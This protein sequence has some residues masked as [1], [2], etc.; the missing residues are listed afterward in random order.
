M[1]WVNIIEELPENG[2]IVYV[3]MR[4]KSELICLYSNDSFGLSDHD[5]K[6]TKWKIAF[7]YAKGD[8]KHPYYSPRSSSHKMDHKD[9]Y[10]SKL[11]PSLGT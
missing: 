4:N 6:V 3:K 9:A 10:S 5:F 7:P 2:T 11:L 8:P 1:N